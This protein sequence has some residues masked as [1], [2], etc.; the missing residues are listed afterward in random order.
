MDS[1][2]MVETETLS[3]TLIK[4][5]SPTPQSLSHYNLSYND[6]NIYPEYIF[7]GFFY[8]NPDGHEISTIREQLQN[9]LSKTLVSYYPF[10]GKVVKNDYIHC[11]DDGIE[12]VDVRIHCRMNDILK[13]ELRSYASELIRPNRSTVGSEDST[14]LV[15]LSHFDCGGVAVAFGISHKVADAAT[16]LSFIKDWAASTCDLSSSHDVSTPVLVSD[17]I[18]PRQDNI[19]CG[20]FPASPNCVR[21]RFLF[22]PEAIERLKSKAIEFGIEKPTRVEVLTAF[23]CRCATVAGKSAAKNNNC[24]QS[25]PFA[26]IQ[27]VNL[28]PLLELPKNSVGNLISIY[29][30]TI[31]ENDTVN[32]EQEFTKLVIGELRKAKDKLKNLS[33]EKLNYVARMQDFA[34]CLKEL[35]ISSFFDMENVDIDAYLFSSWCRFPFYDID[36][37]LGKPI[38]VCMFQPHFKNCIILMDYPF[39]DD[40]GIEALITLEQ[41]KMPAFE[42]NELLLSFASN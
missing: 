40:Y 41:E 5:S 6:Q 18:F 10:A 32:I 12:F 23:L 39:G 11:N 7:A 21:K 24:G 37:G 17:S 15:Q 13:P 42:N 3:K 2:T 14:A 29:F 31:K 19:I 20:Q 28:R 1:I 26:V 35:D 38:W 36:F 9:S 22:S 25:L 16:I 33:Q 8:S 30:S 4:P 34:N 27:A